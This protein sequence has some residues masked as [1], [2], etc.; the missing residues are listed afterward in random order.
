VELG[1]RLYEKI[2]GTVIPEWMEA[3]SALT[4]EDCVNYIHNLT[5]NQT[6]DGYLREKSVVHDCLAKKFPQVVFEESPPELDHAGDVDYIGHVSAD[7]TK[8]IG[9]QIKPV[10]AKANFGNYSPSERMRKS[11]EAFR[12]QFGGRVFIVYSHDGE[13]ANTEVLDEIRA[14]LARIDVFR[15]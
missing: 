4:K 14:E 5:I 10:T 11:F 13:V 9:I 12:A 7:K 8:A 6:F 3:F 15:G 2:K 1:E